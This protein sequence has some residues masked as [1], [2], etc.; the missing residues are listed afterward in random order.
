MFH[1]RTILFPV[2]QASYR[3]G[4]SELSRGSQPASGGV[5]RGHAHQAAPPNPQQ[6]DNLLDLLRRY[7]GRATW[8][9]TRLRDTLF[10]V[11]FSGCMKESHRAWYAKSRDE[12][13]SLSAS[14]VGCVSLP[15][16]GFFLSAVS[17][18]QRRAIKK[19]TRIVHVGSLPSLVTRELQLYSPTLVIICL[20]H[21]YSWPHA[22]DFKCQ[23]LTAFV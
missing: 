19:G 16:T 11:P 17:L 8:H 20:L 15:F 7:P 9:E 12:L 1:Y 18:W 5:A 23:A 13:T 6:A 2:S 21:F 3:Q 22:R 14:K 4:A 10:P